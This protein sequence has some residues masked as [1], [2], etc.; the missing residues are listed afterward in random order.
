MDW[1]TTLAYQPLSTFTIT[2]PDNNSFGGTIMIKPLNLNLD[3]WS[4]LDFTDSEQ[5]EIF[6]QDLIARFES[7]SQANIYDVLCD[8]N[9]HE[10]VK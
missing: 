4:M 1:K 10:Y 3:H 8:F 9:D 5:P 2:V 7:I 6:H